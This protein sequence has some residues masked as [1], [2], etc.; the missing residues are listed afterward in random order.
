MINVVKN[1]RELVLPPALTEEA[2][3]TL[4]NRLA[5]GDT[6]VKTTL[7]EGNLRLVIFVASKYADI[8]GAEIDDLFSV[9]TFGLIKALD[10]FNP[11]KNVKLSTFATVC[12][13][14]AIIKYLQ[15]DCRR[16]N[17]NVSLDAILSDTETLC[18]YK[19]LSYE[20]D[21]FHEIEKE[22]NHKLIQD[23]V[24]QL[25]PRD[26]K[27]VEMCFGLSG[28]KQMKQE[29]IAKCLN[30]KQSCVARSKIHAL[31]KL[32]ELLSNQ[33]CC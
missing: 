31:K 3:Q 6:S 29:E 8:T 22:V 23:A 16:H 12:I 19:V 20:F 9:G 32:R 30:T 13:E 7:I 21:A 24:K 4:L 15:R 10:S 17:K 33:E 27:I 11:D 25:R 2:Q 5:R 18:L 26:K 14:R 28:T 1:F